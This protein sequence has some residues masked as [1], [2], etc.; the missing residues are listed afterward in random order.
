[1][2]KVYTKKIPAIKSPRVKFILPCPPGKKSLKG[3]FYPALSIIPLYLP[4]KTHSTS[5]QRVLSAKG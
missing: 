1:M 5:V 3:Y 4:F 2:R